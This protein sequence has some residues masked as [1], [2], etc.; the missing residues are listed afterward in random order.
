MLKFSNKY[1]W[2]ILKIRGQ[3]NKLGIKVTKQAS[4]YFQLLKYLNSMIFLMKVTKYIFK[5]VK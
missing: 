1:F 5:I 2:S 3:S 4:F